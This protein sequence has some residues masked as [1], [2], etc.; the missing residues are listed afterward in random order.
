[1][2]SV[3]LVDRYCL[4]VASAV[5]WSA[6]QVNSFFVLNNGRN[7]SSRAAVLSVLVDSWLVNPKKNLRSV[8]VDGMGN[9]VMA[10]VTAESTWY[11]FED[12]LSPANVTYLHMNLTL[13]LVKGNVSLFTPL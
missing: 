12:N 2:A 1:M 7:G 5:S 8:C 4:A 11:S 9:F 3:G 6:V 10:S 13:Q